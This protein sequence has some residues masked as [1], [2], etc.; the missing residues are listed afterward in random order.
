[1]DS[2]YIDTLREWWLKKKSIPVMVAFLIAA[3]VGL[4]SAYNSW[5]WVIVPIWVYI[6]TGAVLAAS[7]VAYVVAC[8]LYGALPKAPKDALA[9]L[10]C[11]DAETEQ[12]YETARFKLVD[13]FNRY[14]LEEGASIQAL[15]VS[16]LQVP[17]FN[18]HDKNGTLA[19]LEKTNCILIVDVRY[20]ADNS[21]NAEN[22]ELRINCAV[23]HPKFNDKAEAIISQD[24]RTMKSPVGR[25]NFNNANAINVFNFTA[26]TLV[27]AV[28]YILGFV[29][30][31]SGNNRYAFDLLVRAKNN[32]SANQIESNARKQV[33]KL[34]DDRIFATLCQIC[35]DILISFQSDKDPQKLVLLEK[36]L[37]MANGIYSDTYF[38][39][40]N[41]A[42]VHIALYDN[43][44]AA[45]LCIENCKNSRENKT[46]LYSDAF[47]SAY[48][49]HAPSTILTKY[50]KALRTPYNLVEL[51]DFIEHIIESKPEKM[52]LHLAAGLVYEAIGEVKLMR[53]HLA[54]FLTGRNGISNKA[55]E[56]ISSR[57]IATNCGESCSQDC[58]KCVS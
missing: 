18:L 14:V 15:C 23:S 13:N 8:I 38:Y 22:F 34:V 4:A 33:E 54:V 12:L 6:V 20:T 27:C 28:Q 11:I 29:Y 41:M 51:A 56:Q 32:I 55:R 1:M 49:G 42:Y 10:F 50:A 48:C 21:G 19:L 31:L 53:H 25:Q 3:Y 35:K 44:K 26:H 24:L 16:K 46:W 2:N 39:N 37:N 58:V 40:L 30:L 5:Q 7:G 17:K 57:I 45:K 9:V 47:L 36:C 43:A 52:S